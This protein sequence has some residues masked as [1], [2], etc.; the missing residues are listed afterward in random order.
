VHDRYNAFLVSV[1][2]APMAAAEFLQASPWLN[3]VLT[4]EA[5]RYQ[6]RRPLDPP[7]F[8]Y[9]GGAVRNEAPYDPAVFPKHNDKPLIYVGF[10]SLG[11]ADTDLFRRLIDTFAAAPIPRADVGRAHKDQYETFR[12]ISTWNIG[13]RSPR[14]F[15]RS[16]CSSIT[17]ATI[18]S[19]RR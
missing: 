17:A 11:A 14:S 9:I 12:T 18:H 16:I 1:G 8:A 13:T 15:P 3:L 5:L 6:R 7:T 2:E 19:M 10:G 4:P